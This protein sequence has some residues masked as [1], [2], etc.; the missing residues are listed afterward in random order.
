MTTK[1]NLHTHCTFC[2]G[3]STMEEMVQAAIGAGFVSIGFSSHC[4]TGYSFDSCQ[5]NDVEGYFSELERLKA[6]Y[7]GKIQI[8]KGFELESRVDGEVRPTIDPRCDFTLGAVHLFRTPKGILPVDYTAQAWLEALSAFGSLDALLENYLD[9]ILSFAE[10]SPFD[11]VAH[12]DLFTKFNEKT[13]TFDE[14]DSHYQ[15]LVLSYVD[16]IAKTGK[17]FEV[18]TGAMARGYRSIPYPAPF[19]LKRLLK[20][21]APIIISSDSHQ[22]DTISFAFVQTEQMLKDMG[23]K[24]QMRLTK[25]GFVSVPL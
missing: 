11:I 6:K 8:F 7:E 13:R 19:I 17:I 1:S 3:R 4:H 25:D 24:E 15:S 5:V 16:R 9:E 23:F 10:E 2:D 20:L 18:N 14:K 21:K 12:L 22:A